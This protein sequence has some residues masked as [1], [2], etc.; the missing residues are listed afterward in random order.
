MLNEFPDFKKN[1][2]NFYENL[3]DIQGLENCEHEKHDNC[4]HENEKERHI[5][6]NSTVLCMS[7]KDL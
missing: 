2:V 6:K 7:L 3:I 1:L 5:G 4:P